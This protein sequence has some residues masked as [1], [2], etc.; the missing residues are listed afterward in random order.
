MV[1]H[2]NN[3][4]VVRCGQFVR[5]VKIAK[6]IEVQHFNKKTSILARGKPIKR[7]YFEEASAVYS[8]NS[9][10]K[11]GNLHMLIGVQL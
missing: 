2:A 1:G 4:S 5:F 8:M 7:T 10:F 3:A 6:S 9:L 11:G